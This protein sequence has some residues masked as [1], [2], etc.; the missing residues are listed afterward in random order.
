[1]SMTLG[2]PRP[3]RRNS[4]IL[5]GAMVG[6]CAV[7]IALAAGADDR[8]PAPRSE[9]FQPVAPLAS[10]MTGQK[11]QFE[12]LVALTNDPTAK[13]RAQRMHEA[14]EI[15]AEFGNVNVHHHDASDYREWT[16]ALRDLSLQVAAEARKRD[17]ADEAKIKDLIK[18]IDRTC[19]DCHNKYQ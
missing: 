8:P 12:T 7:C 5:S 18:R 17:K 6:A 14:A 2:A 13:G 11:Q 19:S 10:L 1:M 16:V 4:A 15:L 9:G 3:A